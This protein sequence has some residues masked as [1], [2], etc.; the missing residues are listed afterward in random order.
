M[1]LSE[2]FTAAN[3]HERTAEPVVGWVTTQPKLDK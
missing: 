1:K 2:S 3:D